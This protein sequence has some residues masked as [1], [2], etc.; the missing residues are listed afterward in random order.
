MEHL[1][2]KY[3]KD[4]L[5][6][7]EQHEFTK[8]LQ[9]DERNVQTLRKIT[10]Y[11]K[12]H[13]DNVEKEKQE[14]RSRLRLLM[15][16]EN[17]NQLIKQSSG[18]R[19]L[20]IA[21][22]IAV[23]CSVLLLGV[24]RLSQP[25]QDSAI[26]LTR[27]IEKVSLPGQKITTTLPDGTRVKLNGD[28]KLIVPEKFDGLNRQV[29]LV[30]E[31]FFDVTRDENRP[32]IILTDSLKI[33]VLG[34]SFNVNAYCGELAS[35]AVATGKVSV[36]NQ[37]HQFI[38][39]EPSEMTIMQGATL[40][41]SNLKGD[42][43]PFGWTKQRLVFEDESIENVLKKVSRWYG[44]R[45]EILSMIA[46][47]KRYTASYNNPTIQEMMEVLSY[48]YDFKYKFNEKEKQLIIN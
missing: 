23:I 47:D 5:T 9:S 34:T 20:W 14:V 21:A 38:E 46:T 45:I 27:L 6:L 1:I 12:Y 36:S 3:L 15:A 31:A 28:S 7:D 16:D 13:L 37:H 22:S 35:V 43:D 41:R 19:V 2:P 24:Y 25:A 4:E 44:V 39:L 18:T 11:W 32:F 48:V 17:Q 33:Q 26:E 29:T 40:Q 42:Q 10:I 30:G 8:W